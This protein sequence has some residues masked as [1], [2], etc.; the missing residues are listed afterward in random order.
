MHAYLSL[1]LLS[2]TN[3]AARLIPARL[4]ISLSNFTYAL[5]ISWRQ[6]YLPNTAVSSSAM[7]IGKPSLT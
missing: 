5:S 1:A 3:A 7:T 2:M 4:D 6:S